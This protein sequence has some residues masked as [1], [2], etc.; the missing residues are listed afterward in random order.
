MMAKPDKWE[1]AALEWYNLWG[2]V[3]IYNPA[4]ILAKHFRERCELKEKKR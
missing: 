4:P 1:E 2:K 3:T